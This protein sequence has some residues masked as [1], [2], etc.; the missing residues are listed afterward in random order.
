M[1]IQRTLTA[2]AVTLLVAMA[3]LSAAEARTET[4]PLR[5]GTVV[6]KMD[7]GNFSYIKAVDGEGKEFWVLLSICTIGA[8]G[9]IDVLAGD[10][11]DK[12]RT[13]DQVVMEDVYI[14]ERVRIGDVVVTGFG[15][16]KLPDGCVLME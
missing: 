10:R 3:A 16:H 7:L 12:V 14:G 9:K 4:Q 6:T 15:P 5:S 13:Q 1:G 11:H 8:G 2:V